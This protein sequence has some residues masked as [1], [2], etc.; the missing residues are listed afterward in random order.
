MNYFRYQETGSL[1]GVWQLFSGLADLSKEWTT[2]KRNEGATWDY[3][4]SLEIISSALNGNLV[5]EEFNLKAYEIA[6]ANTDSIELGKR[7]ARYLTIVDTVNGDEDSPVGYGE[8]SSNDSRL[9]SIEDA[10]DLLNDNDEFESYLKELYNIRRSYIVDKGIDPVEMLLNS[11]KGL[12]EAVSG[13]SVLVRDDTLLKDIVFALCENS[14][15]SLQV[16]LEAAF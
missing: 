2:K 10:F 13:I 1:G 4:H 15:N 14:S 12:P 7:R 5:D 8:I 6:C 9:R 16:R 11:L 3:G